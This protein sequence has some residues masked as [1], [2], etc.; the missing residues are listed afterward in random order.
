MNTKEFYKQLMEEYTFDHEKI[1]KAAM[2]PEAPAKKSRIRTAIISASAIA[3]ALAVTIGTT[4]VLSNGNPVSVTPSTVTAEQRYQL[5]AETYQMADEEYGDEEEYF[6]VTFKDE[7]TPS[8]MQ[9]I[10][11][12]V[13]NSGTIKVLT[14]YLSDMNAVTGS[15]N[16]RSMFDENEENIAAVKILCPGNL[17]RKLQDNEL[18]YLVESGDTFKEDAF[19]VL[20]DTDYDY[21][22][23][24]EIYGHR[25]TVGDTT[26]IPDPEA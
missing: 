4:A 1:K 2:Q 21:Q 20:T 24:Y 19:T 5:A 11:L 8:D 26:P 18:I 3:A 17:Y 16:I 25:P 10:L 22:K 13:D 12:S 14:L 9:D 23:D 7:K 15:D 6:Y